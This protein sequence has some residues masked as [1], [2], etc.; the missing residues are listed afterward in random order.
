VIQY[1]REVAIFLLSWSNLVDGHI[2]SI[3]DKAPCL[4]HEW[5]N[6]SLRVACGSS[7]LCMQFLSFPKIYIIVFIFYVYCKV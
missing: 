4:D 6:C 5:S 2:K 7:N 3:C 1:N